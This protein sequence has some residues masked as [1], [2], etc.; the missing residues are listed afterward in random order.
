MKP[1][2]EPKSL[3]KDDFAAPG[4]TMTNEQRKLFSGAILDATKKGVEKQKERDK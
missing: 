3:A 4:K 2:D 1:A